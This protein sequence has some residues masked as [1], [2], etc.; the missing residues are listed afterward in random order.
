MK[1]IGN[2]FCLLVIMLILIPSFHSVAYVSENDAV[3]W[4][5]INL[6]AEDNMKITSLVDFVPSPHYSHDATLF[7]LTYGM[8]KHCLWRSD[9]AGV[10]WVLILHGDAFEVTSLDHVRLS[11]QY[12]TNQKVLYV[13][14]TSNKKPALW[15]SEDGGETFSNPNVSRDPDSGSEFP[16]DSFTVVGNSTLVVGTYDGTNGLLYRTFDGGLH[17]TD[18]AVA[19]TASLNSIAISPDYFEDKMILVGNRS[20]CVYMSFDGGISFESLPVETGMTRCTVEILL[21]C[22]KNRCCLYRV[23]TTLYSNT[24]FSVYRI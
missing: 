12:G 21:C 18:K 13:S 3:S 9:D 20:G 7:L 1:W 4:I 5:Q 23:K 19:G 8:G 24:G 22:L 15:K 10:H 16:I 11:P 14:G 17:Y 6:P 2:N